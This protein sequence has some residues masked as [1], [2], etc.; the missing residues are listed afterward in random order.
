MTELSD[1]YM[2][3]LIEILK[4]IKIEEEPALREAAVMITDSFQAGKRIFGFGCT[5]SSLPIQDVVYRAGGMMLVNPILAP[6]IASL[7]V[8]PTTM[9]SAIEQLEGYA[10]ILLDNQPIEEG[11]VLIIVSMS[12]RNAVPVEMA[13]I[14]SERG[15]KIIG[16]TAFDYTKNV[17][18]R[19]PSGK[20]MY[21]YADIVLDNKVPKGDALIEVANFPYK[22]SPVS[23]VASNAILHALMTMVAE[24]MLARGEEPPVF[25]SGNLDGGAAQNK[26]LLEKHGDRVFY[27]KK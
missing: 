6:G 24:E 13:K 12:G 25:V 14:A 1:R 2:D 23:G 11:D 19:H 15:I 20:K 9:T 22:F 8:H 10:K 7:D 3:G 4:Q 5:H 17:A 27:M 16:I 21:E 26:R 18:S